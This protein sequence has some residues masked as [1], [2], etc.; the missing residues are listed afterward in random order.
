MGIPL[1]EEKL[2]CKIQVELLHRVFREVALL[3]SKNFEEAKI[4][5]DMEYNPDWD[6]LMRFAAGGKSVLITTRY[7]G[8]LVG[9]IIALIGP[10][11]HNINIEYAD[12]ETFYIVPEFRG[13]AALKMIKMLEQ[14]L[15]G[16]VSF[17]LAS[18]PVGTKAN[19]LFDYFDFKPLETVYWKRF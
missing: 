10:Y 4:W 1:E 19:K 13:L 15:R 5:P 18:A 16:K 2:E 9:Y 3:S 12:I 14:E 7:D 8:I 6:E 11:K 17:L